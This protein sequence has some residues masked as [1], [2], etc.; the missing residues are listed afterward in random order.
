MHWTSGDPQNRDALRRG[1]VQHNEHI[2][3]IV[4]KD[5]LLDFQVQEGWEPLCKFLG[6]PV[7]DEP[8]PHAN[9]GRQVGDDVRILLFVKA[10]IGYA[11]PIAFGV[12]S[13][14]VWRYGC[15]GGGLKYL[16]SSFNRLCIGT[17]GHD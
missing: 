15:T 3:F 17:R 16:S 2:R 6:K 10:L 5:K 13:W 12:L 4:P 8:F 1:F 9:E 11:V 14:A 7:P